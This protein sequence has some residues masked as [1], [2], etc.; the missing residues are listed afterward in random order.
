MK[1]D[2]KPQF[3]RILALLTL[4][5]LLL[6]ACA[7]PDNP[8]PTIERYIEARV[9]ADL[10]TM[11]ALSCADWELQAVVEAST[12]QALNASIEGMSCQVDGEEGDATR[13]ACTGTIVTD[14]RGEERE[15]DLAAQ[16]F[17]ATFEGG[18]WR[19]CGYSGQ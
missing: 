11:V 14:Y 4:L 6:A 2:N 17:L 7:Q 9:A 13:V 19:M 15:W 1:P 3:N 8:V 16:T 10:D 18:D 5:A 12:F